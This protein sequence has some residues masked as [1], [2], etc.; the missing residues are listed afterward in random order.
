MK[1]LK[2]QKVSMQQ[3]YSFCFADIWEGA[4]DGVPLYKRLKGY[5]SRFPGTCFSYWIE[6]QLRFFME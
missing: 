5:E 4:E 6:D 3:I 1:I 2:N